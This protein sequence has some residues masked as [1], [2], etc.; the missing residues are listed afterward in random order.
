MPDAGA[1]PPF[2]GLRVLDLSGEIA[3]GY[4]S[5]LLV[6]AGADVIV[7]EPPG[8]DPLRRFTS[9][10]APLPDGED[11]VLFGFLRASARA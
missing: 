10:I 6:D 5:K 8:G 9:A 2:D 7:V 4:A 1:V 3:G 11:G